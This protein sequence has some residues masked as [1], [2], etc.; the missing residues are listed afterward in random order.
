MN[1]PKNLI[2]WRR[3]TLLISNLIA[4]GR[5]KIIPLHHLLT[6]RMQMCMS[7]QTHQANALILS[8]AEIT[9]LPL[10][11]EAVLPYQ[12]L[13]AQ[14]KVCP[15]LVVERMQS[16]RGQSR[17]IRMPLAALLS[18]IQLAAT[19]INADVLKC[20]MLQILYQDMFECGA[21][22]LKLIVRVYLQRK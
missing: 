9:T 5:T 4:Q 20:E 12:L 10:V 1:T 15:L 16:H 22:G 18:P 17:V 13:L 21:R 11:Q 7:T 6:P 2:W 19:Q 3:N 14:F 8:Q